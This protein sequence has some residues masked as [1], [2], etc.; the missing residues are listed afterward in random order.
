MHRQRC[1]I[2]NAS[3]FTNAA[4]PGRATPAPQETGGLR[5]LPS[6][7]VG[8]GKPCGHPLQSLSPALVVVTCGCL[9]CVFGSGSGPLSPQGHPQVSTTCVERIAFIALAGRDRLAQTID[10]RATDLPPA[11]SARSSV[12]TFGFMEAS[13]WTRSGATVAAIR[14]PL[15]SGERYGPSLPK[16]ARMSNRFLPKLQL[17]WVSAPSL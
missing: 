16:A 10:S 9:P 4:N 14:D 12:Q 6:C 15:G 17:L 13:C 8:R 2:P 11:M 7:G 1:L 5:R 3:A